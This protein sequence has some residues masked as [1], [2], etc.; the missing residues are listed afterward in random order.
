MLKKRKLVVLAV[1][2]TL[3]AAAPA[4]AATTWT[5]VPSGTAED[6]TALEYRSDTQ[7]WFATAGGQ[8]WSADAGGT[9]QLRA[10]FPGK[11]FSDIAFRP[12]GTVGL[13]TTTT[14]E[15]YRSPNGGLNWD[16]RILVPVYRS[17]AAAADPTAVR[18]LDAIT[19]ASNTT[20]YVV[21]GSSVTQPIIERS[22]D[23][24]VSWDEVNYV[25]GGGCRVGVTGRPI[26]DAWANLTAPLSLRFV[27]DDF[28]RVYRSDDGLASDAT[29]P[30]GMTIGSGGVPRMAVDPANPERLWVVNRDG[31]FH[32]SE[33]GGSDRRPVLIAGAP[34]GIRRNLY[35][36]AYAGGTLVA[37][38]DGGEIFTSVDGKNAYLQ[39]AAAPDDGV[40]WRAV[41]V[42]DANRALVG[43]AGGKLV[44][45]TN[46]N[47]IPAP[48]VVPPVVPPV[49]PPVTPP[50]STPPASRPGERTGGG[51][52][53]TTTPPNVEGR[54]A[55]QTTGGARVAWWK[56]VALSKG[57]YVPVR[58]SARTPRRFVIEI[59]R[60]RR[61]RRRI[62][63]AKARLGRNGRA[64]IRVPLRRSTRTGKYRIVVRVYKGRRA[65]GRRVDVAFLI[66]R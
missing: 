9:F 22:T 37:V 58:I 43:G 4:G 32:W 16:Q 48:P 3:A 47:A 7:A 42:A 36:V 51:S 14:G 62:A 10:T 65:I 26:T 54:P 21:G 55:T 45:T 38:G 34:L 52:S 24:G 12:D 1:G 30:G 60:A 28:G 63:M 20:A 8:I 64:L 31:N 39:R 6:I 13:A 25:P 17:C 41:D 33:A 61:P 15:L 18:R 2:A 35:D 44:K 66:V 40:N 46:A 27:T 19:W 29:S 57:R 56:R 23:N 50:T 5:P 49:T 11:S 53:T 59:R